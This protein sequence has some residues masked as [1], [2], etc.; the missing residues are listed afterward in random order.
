MRRVFR[1]PPLTPFVKKL[2]IGLA[3]TFVVTLLAEKLAGVPCFELLALAPTIGI[4]SA[5]QIFTYVLVYPPEPGSVLSLGIGLVFLW[6][7]AGPFEQRFGATRTVQLLLVGTVA[8][9]VTTLIAAQLLPS[10][11]TF[12]MSPFYMAIVA[13]YAISLPR[14]ARLS[15]FGI[16][17]LK[18]MGIIW[19]FIGLSALM[20]IAADDWAGLMG[21]LA[22]VGAG[23][24][25]MK[26]ILRPQRAKP[27]KK[28]KNGSRR[29]HGFRV[30]EG[31]ADDD[32][33]DDGGPPRYLN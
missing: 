29:S 28:K 11:I 8:A 15:F 25:F 1:F 14:N 24:L 10:S 6:W 13:G 17:P 5:W 30:I 2:L 26:W 16:L 7:M 33:D 21:D 4:Y 32:D 27:K 9:G 23:V 20:H 18:P 3:A 12:G 31:G 22:A 19:L